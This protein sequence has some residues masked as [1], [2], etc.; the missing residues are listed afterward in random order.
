METYYTLPDCQISA[1][2]ILSTTGGEPLYGNSGS[3]EKITM[4][5]GIL[6]EILR[7][8]GIWLVKVTK[9]KRD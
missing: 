9:G 5:T 1:R 8:P 3:D 2:E 7:G 4:G 6:I